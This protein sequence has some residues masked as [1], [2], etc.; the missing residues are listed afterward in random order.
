[1]THSVE[2]W[3][4]GMLIDLW[5]GRVDT[6][7]SIGRTDVMRACGTGYPALPIPVAYVNLSSWT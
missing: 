2:F 3:D 1:M 4:D 7:A 6:C 5:N